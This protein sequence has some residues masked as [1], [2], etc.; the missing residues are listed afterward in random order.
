MGINGNEDDSNSIISFSTRNFLD[1]SCAYP[2]NYEITDDYKV[3]AS[4]SGG[5]TTGNGAFTFNLFKYTDDSHNTPLS[6]QG[7]RVGEFLY[8]AAEISQ[9]INSIDF[10]ASDCTVNVKDD[11]STKFQI[12]EEGC[13]VDGNPVQFVSYDNL[14]QDRVRFSYR[15]FEFK[16]VVSRDMTLKCN[17]VVCDV[18][19]VN[20][21]CKAL[22]NKT[23]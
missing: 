22:G 7:V 17:I 3:V 8:F 23:C 12:F 20:S 2:T 13:P 4:V 15:A 5:T 18:D 14:D 16:N 9:S 11:D 19:D 10:S 1:F 6:A 21:N